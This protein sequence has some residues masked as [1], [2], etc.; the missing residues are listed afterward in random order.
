M[1]EDKTLAELLPASGGEWG[2]TNVDEA[3]RQFLEDIFEESVMET[4]KSDP[5]NISD[6][7]EFWQNF[8]VKKKENL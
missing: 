8:E 4:F 1:Q 5:D 6:Y 2:G 7:I 3:Y